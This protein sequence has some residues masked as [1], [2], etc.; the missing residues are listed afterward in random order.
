MKNISSPRPRGPRQDGVR[1]RDAILAAARDQFAAHGYGGA[2]MRAIAG[3]AGVDVALVSYYFGSKSGLFMESLR[4]PVNPAD[5]IDGLVA[6]G[7]D[8]LGRRALQRLLVVWDNPETGG[9]LVSVLRS[10]T[11]QADIL[12]DFVERQVATR[13]AGVIDGPDSELR[14]TAFTS[15]VLGLIFHRYVL[16]V[17]PMASASH[18]EIIE[19]VAPTLQRY[20]TPASVTPAP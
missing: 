11:S 16:R 17:E 18:E 10:A 2:T 8:D 12:R 6:E 19:L 3:A 14:A 13:I 5:A 9:P 15:Q 4:L 7:P 20:L 1:A